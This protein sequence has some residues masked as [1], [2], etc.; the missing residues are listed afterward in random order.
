MDYGYEIA[1]LRNQIGMKQE[2][3]DRLNVFIKRM[4]DILSQGSGIEI[5][6]TEVIQ[7]EWRDMTTNRAQ[8]LPAHLNDVKQEVRVRVNQMCQKAE[9]KKQKLQSQIN[10]YEQSIQQYRLKALKEEK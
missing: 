2:D 10:Q 1:N 3:V 7:S 9:E 8:S 5:A 4:H 6:R